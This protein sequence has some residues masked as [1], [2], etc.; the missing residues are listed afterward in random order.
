MGNPGFGIGTDI[1][2][3][4]RME[5]ILARAG[6]LFLRR[7]FTDGE[8]REGK[9]AENPAA[10]FASS[11]AAKEAAIKALRPGGEAPRADFTDMEV[12]RGTGGEPLIRLAGQAAALAESRGIGSLLLSVS[13]EEEYALAVV[14]AVPAVFSVRTL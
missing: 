5:E 7:V 3:L 2:S 6:D 9:T 14:L 10:Y 4:P 1:V 12:D 8:I 13:R 11:F